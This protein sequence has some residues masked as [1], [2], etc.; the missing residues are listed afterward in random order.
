MISTRLRAVFP[1]SLIAAVSALLTACSAATT[2]SP[3]ANPAPN[4]ATAPASAPP[5]IYDYEIIN[6]YPHDS[7]AFTQGL[8]FRDGA[9]YESTGL[10]GK[11]SIR[12]VDL[13]TG[14]VLK[15]YDLP[16]NYF[17]EGI[18]SWKKRIIQITWR[19]QVGFVYNLDSFSQVKSFTYP[20]EGWG[21]TEDGRRLI[22]SDGTADLRFLDPKKLREIGR[23]RVTHRGQPVT[24]LNELEYV[25]RD[26]YANIWR[27]DLI[28]RIDPASGQVNGVVDLRG[29]RREL[30]P[31]GTGAEVLNGIAYDSA[32]DRLF[33]T[34]KL[35]P[36]LFEIRLIARSSDPQ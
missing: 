17:G 36:K 26:V 33:V 22:M 2:T 8:F 9:L 19:S 27:S 23:V 25:Y 13:E 24:G 20:G 32:A 12:K 15:K 6:T 31:G 7:D 28:V 4:P 35:W 30:G 14:E 21:I 11:S 3:E 1:L 10:K 34:G 29:L 16:A 18:T 5:T